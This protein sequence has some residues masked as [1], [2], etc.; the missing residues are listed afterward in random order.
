[1]ANEFSTA[2][3]TVKWAVEQTA[4]TRPT[5][6]YSAI[7]GIKSTPDMNPEPSS[8]DVTDLADKFFK[9]FIDG[10]KDLSGSVAFRANLT[11]DLKTSW[12]AM[13]SAYETA[14]ASGKAIWF[15]IAIPNFESFYFAGY[16][17]TLGISGFEVDSVA[18]IDLYIVPNQIEGWDTASTTSP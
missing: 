14:K 12:E 16:P 3:V 13:Y 10:L 2:G 7:K 11:S 9:R 17:S 1:M 18:E 15:E 5:V 6:N 8:L 4:G